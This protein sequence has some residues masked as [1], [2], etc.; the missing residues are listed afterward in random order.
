MSPKGSA[1]IMIQYRFPDHFHG[2]PKYHTF[3]SNIIIKIQYLESFTFINWRNQ[4]M[5]DCVIVVLLIY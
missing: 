3:D 1:K 4:H 2:V 5:D